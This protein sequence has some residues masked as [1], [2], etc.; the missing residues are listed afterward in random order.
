MGAARGA[1]PRPQWPPFPQ[2]SAAPRQSRDAPRFTVDDLGRA[3]AL[4]RDIKRVISLA[5]SCTDS[6]VAIGGGDR[7]VGVEEHSELPPHLGSVPRVGGF[8]DVDVERVLDLVPDLVLTASLH[9]VA[10]APQVEAR[11]I[12]VFAMAPRTI[13]GV[14]D[15]MARLAALLDLARDVAPYVAGCRQRIARIVERALT[16]RN[17]PLVY[18]ECSPEGHTGGPSSFLDDLVTK[19]G[20]INLGGVARVEWPVVSARMVRRFDPDVI[21]I[22]S[23]PRSATRESIIARDGW[24]R[25]GAVKSDRVHEVPAPMLK[26]PGP[27]VIDGLERVAS[28]LAETRI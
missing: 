10:I 4:G 3:V 11:R 28:L 12:P 5:P 15:G 24:E 6:L 13:D 9:A 18:V 2:P 23:Y 16:T 27:T 22:A 25:L 1:R 8:K 19:A 26:R 17:R 21:V 7:L 20:G 14:V